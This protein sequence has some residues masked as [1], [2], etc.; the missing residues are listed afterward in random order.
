VSADADEDRPSRC[1]ASSRRADRRGARGPGCRGGRPRPLRCR[2]RRRSRRVPSG[3]ADR[4]ALLR[5]PPAPGAGAWVRSG[6][7]A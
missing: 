1:C 4:S 5:R 7:P 3:W 2:G 6:R